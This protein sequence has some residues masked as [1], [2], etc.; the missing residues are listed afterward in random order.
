MYGLA[1][2]L[3]ESASSDY[4]NMSIIISLINAV[5]NAASLAIIVYVF[6]G[7]FVQPYNPIRQALS[8]FF[9]PIFIKVRKIVPPIGMIDLSPLILLI[10]LQILQ[11]MVISIFRLF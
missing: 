8:R 9:E 10:A 4:K 11:T 1:R 6:L 2:Q 5:F 7:Y 3:W